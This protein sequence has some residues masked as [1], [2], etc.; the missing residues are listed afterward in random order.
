MKW[1]WRGVTGTAAG[2][3]ICAA[4]LM[5]LG[6]RTDA[7]V[8]RTGIEIAQS[9][10]ALWPWLQEPDK[11]KAWVGWLVEV[12]EVGANHQL[13]VMIDHDLGDQRIEVNSVA[14]AKEPPRHMVAHVS[15]PGAFDG[16]ETYW[17]TDLGNGRTWLAIECRYLYSNWFAKLLEPLI[18]RQASKK[19]IDDVSK[20]KSVTEARH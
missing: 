19:L 3:L 15:S 13:W 7:G 6:R 20:L 9:R 10:D 12:R 18:T 1:V 4:V 14:T 8:F 16:E 17:L 5:A 2:L 11:L